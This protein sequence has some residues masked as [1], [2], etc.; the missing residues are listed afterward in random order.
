M[1]Y[2]SIVKAS[3]DMYTVLPCDAFSNDV[4]LIPC[5]SFANF[6]MFLAPFPSFWN[7]LSLSLSLSLF[8]ENFFDQMPQQASPGGPG[9]RGAAWDAQPSVWLAVFGKSTCA[10]SPEG[11]KTLS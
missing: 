6:S 5:S 9:G 10:L 11:S 7:V 1:C 2:A 3:A 4:S 8:F